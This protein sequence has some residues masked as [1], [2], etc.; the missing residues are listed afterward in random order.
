MVP[1]QCL[2]PAYGPGGDG[3]EGIVEMGTTNRTTVSL[4]QRQFW[5]GCGG[6]EGVGEP[7][8]E[9]VEPRGKPRKW[10]AVVARGREERSSIEGAA[11]AARG[12]EG[13]SSIAGVA[14]AAPKPRR[15][16]AGG[17]G[18]EAAIVAGRGGREHSEV[19]GAVWAGSTAKRWRGSIVQ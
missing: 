12:G 4:G 5:G 1:A 3:E 6:S 8:V 13:R 15:T 10:G 9:E 18:V 19:R 16:R 2:H 7:G 14:V 17:G 11:V